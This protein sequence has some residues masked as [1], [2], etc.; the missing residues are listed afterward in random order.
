MH[1]PFECKACK[2][3]GF[4]GLYRNPCPLCYGSGLHFNNLPDIAAWFLVC[5]AGMAFVGVLYAFSL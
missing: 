5:V 3:V 1:N 4:V 2:G